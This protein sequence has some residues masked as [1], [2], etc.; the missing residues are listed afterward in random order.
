MV[1]GSVRP[2]Q[3]RGLSARDRAILSKFIRKGRVTVGSHDV[4][5]EF[6]LTQPNANK[7]LLRLER[8]GWLQRGKR[9]VYI[10]VPLSSVSAETIPED[11]WALAMELFSPCYISG[12]SAAEYW[13][14]TEQI[15]NTIVV[16][17]SR[18]QRSTTQKL[19]NVTFRLHRIAEG[20]MFGTRK[21]WRN[22]IPVLV[23]D[24]HRTLIDVLDCPAFGG[25]GRHALDIAYAYWKSD[26]ADSDLLLQYALR[27]NRGVIFKRLGFSGESWG[28][29]TKEWLETCRE[30]V[31]AG[32][33]KLDPSGPG[34]GKILTRWGL[35]INLPLEEYA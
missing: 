21:I 15:F 28:V 18:P 12:F 31:S 32:I 29:V 24:P 34:Q 6:D 14:L 8:K 13:E 17:S 3:T 25:G 10:F 7:I 2:K 9:D 16:Y 19:A 1:K 30:H 23:A 11:P 33:S 27:L 26:K 35:R 4:A 20:D 22:N 5:K